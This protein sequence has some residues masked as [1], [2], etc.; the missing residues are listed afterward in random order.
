MNGAPYQKTVWTTDAWKYYAGAS[1]KGKDQ[2]YYMHN[3]A[4]KDLVRYY[5]AERGNRSRLSSARLCGAMAPGTN[6][7]V[8]KI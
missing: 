4:L 1:G 2:D 3:V 8:V 5:I 7:F 6:T